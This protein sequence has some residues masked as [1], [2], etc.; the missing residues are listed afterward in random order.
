MISVVWRGT[1]LTDLITYCSL[2]WWA[3][4]YSC[5]GRACPSRRLCWTGHAE[6]VSQLRTLVLLTNVYRLKLEL[7]TLDPTPHNLTKDLLMYLRKLSTLLALI[8]HNIHKLIIYY[9]ILLIIKL[10]SL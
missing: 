10:C 8:H 4:A 5:S 1:A 6:I 7:V 9:F 3:T 2:M